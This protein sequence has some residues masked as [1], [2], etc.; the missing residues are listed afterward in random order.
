MWHAAW[1]EF[2][3]HPLAGTGA[4]TYQQ[5]WYATRPYPAHVLDAHGLYQQTLG[6]LGLVGFVVLVV[7]LVAP[8]IAAVKA[9]R[10]PFVPVACAA[11]VAFLVHNAIDWDWELTG[12]EAAGLL[13][14]VALVVS[15]DRKR[16]GSSSRCRSG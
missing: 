16:P 14:G 13:C 4:G 1:R 6:E 10:N 15:R 5:W 9:R 7:L 8:L 2:V 3:H 12:V 11:Y